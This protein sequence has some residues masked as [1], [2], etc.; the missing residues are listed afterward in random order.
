MA[1]SESGNELSNK[2]RCRYQY[3]GALNMLH[4]CSPNLFAR[5]PFLAS[6]NCHGSSYILT[7]VNIECRND[8][9]PKL[10]IYISE[11]ILDSYEYILVLYV[12][13]HWVI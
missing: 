3:Y 10:K 6:K 9:H 2:Q 12:I 8:M 11:I 7:H 4:Q 5:G 13:M 1:V